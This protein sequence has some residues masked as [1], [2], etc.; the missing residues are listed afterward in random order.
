MKSPLWIDLSAGISGERFAA[1]LI[2]LG[3]PEREMIQVI[4]SASNRFCRAGLGGAPA[5]RGFDGFR[6]HTYYLGYVRLLSA[7]KVA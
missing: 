5:G 6:V 1:A 7:R 2:G 3:A 4:R